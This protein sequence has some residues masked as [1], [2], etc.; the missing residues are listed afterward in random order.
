[1]RPEVLDYELLSKARAWLS[2]RK[3]WVKNRLFRGRLFNTTGNLEDVTATC[4]VGALMMAAGMNDS[5]S[6]RNLHAYKLLATEANGNIEGFNDKTST[7]HKK[8]LGLFDRAMAK[9]KALATQ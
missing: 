3:H 2:N 6:I 4:A 9:A 7:T 8:I 1:M 5:V